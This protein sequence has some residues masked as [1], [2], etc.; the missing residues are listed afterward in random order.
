MA[1][2]DGSAVSATVI[3]GIQPSSYKKP[4]SR[5]HVTYSFGLQPWHKTH[6]QVSREVHRR[7]TCSNEEEGYPRKKAGKSPGEEHFPLFWKEYRRSWSRLFSWKPISI[8]RFL[9]RTQTLS[10][11]WW[12]RYI[13]LEIKHSLC[14]SEAFC[15]F[16]PWPHMG[17]VCGCKGGGAKVFVCI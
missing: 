9:Y 15:Q 1:Q 14:L 3:H 5:C 7:G 10:M 16:V 2:R 4:R 8:C 11:R 6:S 17:T 13:A 12:R